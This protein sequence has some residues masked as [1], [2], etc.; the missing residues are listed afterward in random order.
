MFFGIL[1]KISG[2]ISSIPD[3]VVGGMTTFLFCNVF[4]SGLKVVAQ[5][6]LN[7]R[8]NR[9]T[10]ALSMGLGLGVAMV[11]SVVGDY[12][13]SYG[14]TAFWP[15]RGAF[16]DGAACSDSERAIRDGVVIFL[17]TPYCIGTVVAIIMNLILPKDMEIVRAD[18]PA[19]AGKA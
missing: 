18:P 10:L 4:V 8:R 11:P 19:E 5:S 2:I 6:D 16:R 7:S 15:C 14:T 17:G 9:M 13:D 1:A 12:R 3:S